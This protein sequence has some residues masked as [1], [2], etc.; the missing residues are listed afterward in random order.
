MSYEGPAYEV[1]YL[2]E[3]DDVDPLRDEL[4]ALG[5]SLVVVGGDGLW[6]VHVH[7]DDAGAAIEAGLRVGRP[8]RIR[9]TYLQTVSEPESGSTG[10]GIVAVAHGP[11]IAELLEGLGVT[12]VP[13]VPRRRPSTAELLGAIRQSHADEV[14]VLPSDKDT[15]AVA[16]AAAE[17]ARSAGV[18]VSVIPTRAIVQTLAAVAVH[19]PAARFDDDVVAMTRAAGATRYGAVTIASRRALTTAGACEAGD[20]LG[21]VDGDIVLVGSDVDETIRD[22]LSGMLAIGGELTTLVW[23]VDAPPGL[24]EGVTR[25]IEERFPLVEVA[26]FDGGQPLWPLI[27]GVE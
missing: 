17:Q 11:G 18:R 3:A 23:G 25:W 8:H 15:R 14:V 21:L 13:A 9:V 19:D 26:E 27:I 5:D 1:M 2:L 22:L 20:V 6:N 24:R 4:D 7:V 12:I 10:R 16:E